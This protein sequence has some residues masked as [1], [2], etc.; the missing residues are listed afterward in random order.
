[1]I[2]YVDDYP[3]IIVN[4]TIFGSKFVPESILSEWQLALMR[5]NGVHRIQIFHL[6]LTISEWAKDPDAVRAF[7]L[8]KEAFENVGIQCVDSLQSSGQST[9]TI[10]D[11]VSNQSTTCTGSVHQAAGTQSDES[12]YW[13]EGVSAIIRILEAIFADFPNLS[14]GYRSGVSHE[15]RSFA[16]AAFE[17]GNS[18]GCHYEGNVKV[19]ERSIIDIVEW[20]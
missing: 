13:A 4:G 11:S 15:G 8:L 18:S 6:L 9:A 17:S 10:G 16:D 7:T 2:D 1:M 14:G 19:A 20:F 12:T 5:V 3:S